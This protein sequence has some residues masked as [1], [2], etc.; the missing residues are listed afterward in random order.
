M[1]DQIW[2]FINA[3]GF[4]A[5]TATD[6]LMGWAGECSCL[7]KQEVEPCPSSVKLVY[8]RGALRLI[9]DNLSLS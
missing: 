6:I 9:T 1:P 5:D 3:E 7:Q 8:R 2:R 4:C